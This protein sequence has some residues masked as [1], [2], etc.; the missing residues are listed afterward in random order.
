M[1]STPGRPSGQQ[2]S[3]PSADLK[4]IAGEDVSNAA[5]LVLISKQ[6]VEKERRLRQF[7][8]L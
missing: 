4:I 6:E 1:S 5:S 3:K 7:R 8:I 2:P